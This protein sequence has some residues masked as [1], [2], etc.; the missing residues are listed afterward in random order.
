MIASAK[1]AGG[2]VLLLAWGGLAWAQDPERI[3][4]ARLR[5]STEVSAVAAC[6]RIGQVTDDSLKDLRRKIVRLGGDAAV[7]SFG[8]DD[9]EIIHAQ[10]FRCA[11]PPPAAG[12][13]PAI[14]PPPPGTPPPPPPGPTR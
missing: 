10:V 13:P 9:L 2:A 8:V 11:Q 7:L 1:A 12:A 6:I 3:A 5:L 4:M 14:P